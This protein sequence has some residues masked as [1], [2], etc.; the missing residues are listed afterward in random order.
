M[1]MTGNESMRNLIE[2]VSMWVQAFNEVLWNSLKFSEMLRKGQRKLI[3]HRFH[4]MLYNTSDGK[5]RFG[6][7][8]FLIYP[9]KVESTRIVVEVVFAGRK[10]WPFGTIWREEKAQSNHLRVFIVNNFFSFFYSINFSL[11]HISCFNS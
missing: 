9:R 2:D 3:S 7:K 11:V 1:I 5:L 10:H 4:I 6:M 8:P